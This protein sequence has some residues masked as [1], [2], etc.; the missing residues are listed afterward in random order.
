MKTVC[1][2]IFTY[3]HAC[4]YTPKPMHVYKSQLTLVLVVRL[5]VCPSTC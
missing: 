1:M 2:Y 4:T 3:A 5:S